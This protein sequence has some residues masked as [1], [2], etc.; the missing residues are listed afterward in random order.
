MFGSIFRFF[1][2][3]GVKGILGGVAEVARVVKGDRAARDRQAH[4]EFSGALAQFRAEFGGPRL[5]WWDSLIDG[6]NRL[7]RP[8]FAF[9][10]IGG[11]GFAASD[12]VGFTAI[13]T[14]MAVI[15]DQLWILVGL[16]VSF[17]FGARQ[18]GDLS[19]MRAAS[20]EKVAKTLAAMREIRAMRPAQPPATMDSN[21]ALVSVEGR[22][23]K[24]DSNPALEAW[25]T[26]I[27]G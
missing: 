9:G 12:P 22:A 17:F 14:A 20:P 25:R 15:P 13:M 26:Q 16:V 21:P 19:R 24:M 4:D 5:T 7:P 1:T 8:A 2:G 3:G 27:K 6:L 23:A 11:L 10:V 18:L